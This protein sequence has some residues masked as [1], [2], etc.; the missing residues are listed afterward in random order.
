MVW[1]SNK[2]NMDDSLNV[3][4]RE[5]TIGFCTNI[6]TMLSTSKRAYR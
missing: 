2:F 6:T 5:Q 1:D 3:D 4:E